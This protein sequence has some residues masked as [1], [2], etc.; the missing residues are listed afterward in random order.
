MVGELLVR[1][2]CGVTSDMGARVWVKGQAG[3][4]DRIGGREGVSRNGRVCSRSV[5]A[6]LLVGTFRL[7]AGISVGRFGRR[8][9][10]E[11]PPLTGG[12]PAQI[13]TSRGRGREIDEI[14]YMRGAA[15]AAFAPSTLAV[16]AL[17]LPPR[18]ALARARAST[19]TL[20]RV[21]ESALGGC[22]AGLPTPASHQVTPR[23]RGWT[24]LEAALGRRSL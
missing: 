9:A 6:V 14:A 18:P 22:A 13:G 4:W 1:V 15:D 19:P 2:P 24:I 8:V 21:R 10:R 5:G 7:V 16:P 20:V 3:G 11:A 17:A 23:R 12:A